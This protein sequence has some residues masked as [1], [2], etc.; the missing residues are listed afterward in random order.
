MI[1]RAAVLCLIFPSVLHSDGSWPVGSERAFVEMH[2][3]QVG[4]IPISFDSE[5]LRPVRIAAL[6]EDRFAV[7]DYGSHSVKAFSLDG[8]LL[9]SFGRAGG[10][11]SEF[12]QVTRLRSADSHLW[13]TDVANS[14]VTVLDPAGR[15]VRSVRLPG[16]CV[17]VL[18]FEGEDLVCFG[19]GQDAF[20]RI[21]RGDGT[22]D[23]LPV[24]PPLGGLSHLVREGGAVWVGV[25]AP[26]TVAGFFHSGHLATVGTEG[27]RLQAGVEPLAFPELLQ[28]RVRDAVVTRVS[29]DAA[30]GMRSIGSVGSVVRLLFGG[31]SEQAGRIVDEYDAG[32]LGYLRSFLLP[33][34]VRDLAWLDHGRVAALILEPEPH[35]VVWE[36]PQTL[37]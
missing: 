10:G 9:W 30:E 3:Q 37:H 17:T 2:W 29:P 27:V 21:I 5:L 14:R 20:A 7:F 1:A 6:A 11:P 19:S 35:V 16:A 4:G 8:R 13:V 22:V 23:A 26:R 36:A 34:E 25:A 31:E 15:E 33:S 24:P 32:T 12:R 28:Y 18:P